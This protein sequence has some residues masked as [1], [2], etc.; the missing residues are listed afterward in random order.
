M[1]KFYFTITHDNPSFRPKDLFLLILRRSIANSSRWGRSWP[2]AYTLVN[3]L[4]LPRYV[5][6]CTLREILTSSKTREL[7]CHHRG[8]LHPLQAFD[9]GL[10]QHDTLLIVRV[11]I[12][13]CSLCSIRSFRF[14]TR[15]SSTRLEDFLIKHYHGPMFFQPIYV[16][17]SFFPSSAQ[18]GFHFSKLFSSQIEVHFGGSDY[19]QL[20]ESRKRKKK[21]KKIS[22]PSGIRTHSSWSG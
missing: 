22:I 15:D 16:Y 6:L 10:Q 20:K 17:W 4:Q 19:P 7:F 8:W 18:L 21:K 12:R 13:N 14:G 11:Q 2:W 5:T 3:N 9:L 1:L